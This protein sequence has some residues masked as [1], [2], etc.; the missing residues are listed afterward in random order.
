MKVL[1]FDEIVRI[2]GIHLRGIARTAQLWLPTGFKPAAF[3]PRFKPSAL[4]PR[5]KLAVLLP[6]SAPAALPP[7]VAANWANFNDGARALQEQRI[8]DAVRLLTRSA[9]IPCSEFDVRNLEVKRMACQHLAVAVHHGFGRLDE[10]VFWWREYMRLSRLIAQ[11][12][13]VLDTSDLQIYDTFW[14]KHLGHTAMLGIRAKR[15]LLDG[16]VDQ[17][18]H[19]IRA[20][21]PDEG[22][23]YL[24]EQLGRFFTLVDGP[25][26]LPLR[27]ECI[28]YIGKY[29]FIDD[30]LIGPATYYWQVLAEVSQGWEDKGLGP[31]LAFSDE[32]LDFGVRQRATM[33]VPRT[34]WHVA[35]HVRAAGYKRTHDDLHATLNADIASYELAINAVV[36][37]GGWVIRM[38]DPSMPRL[39]PMKN[40]IDYAHLPEKSPKMD[41]FL[42]GACRFYIGTSSG[43]AYVPAL[44]GVPSVITNWFPTG[45]RPVNCGDLFIPKLHWYE[46]EREFAPFDESMS[47]PLGHIH[48]GSQ[49]A[50][51]GISLRSNTPEELRDVV[52]EMLDRLDGGVD[53]TAEDKQLQSCFDAVALH[54]RSYG[55]ARVGRKF[56]SEFQNLVPAA[57]MN[58]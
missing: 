36:K 46:N 49:L 40:V 15:Y 23:S 10:G 44:Y 18:Q 41:I 50:R 33:G 58:G 3:L 51:L 7:S 11:N 45:T 19:L 2:A 52:E 38:G 21:G 37:R 24:V 17:K 22:N 53:Y 29:F 9:N 31:L 30:R 35:L 55:N 54:A 47:Q 56:L 34:A 13:G 5:F 43:P 14:S 4:L 26:Q 48:A 32:D 42:L 57:A 1:A 28:D 12:Y 39:P 16:K 25:A 6:E 27:P 20:R 8:P